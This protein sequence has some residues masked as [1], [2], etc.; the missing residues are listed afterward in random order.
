MTEPVAE[1]RMAETA[2]IYDLYIDRRIVE[3]DVGEYDLAGALRRAR[4]RGPARIEIA[5]GR[6]EVIVG[7][8]GA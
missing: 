8:Y 3:Y 4:H 6:Y 2:G 1:F 7:V 5:P